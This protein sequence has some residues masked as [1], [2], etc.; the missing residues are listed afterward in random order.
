[1]SHH[2]LHG[3]HFPLEQH[4]NEDGW[5]HFCLLHKSKGRFPWQDY[6]LR[7]DSISLNTHGY[8][9]GLERDGFL[10]SAEWTLKE[11]SG[12][13]DPTWINDPQSQRCIAF[14]SMDCWVLR[15]GNLY[16]I[17][18]ITLY[19][20]I[21][22][23]RGA[24]V[25]PACPGSCSQ[26]SQSPGLSGWEGASLC[27]APAEQR[28][29]APPSP[30]PGTH[31]SSVSYAHNSPF[32]Q[33]SWETGRNHWI[34]S[35]KDWLRP[36]CCNMVPANSMKV[37]TLSFHIQRRISCH[38]NRQTMLFLNPSLATPY[39]F[40]FSHLTFCAWDSWR[41]FPSLP[42]HCV[43][44]HRKQVYLQ[45]T[46]PPPPRRPLS[47]YPALLICTIVPSHSAH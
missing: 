2:C 22:Y 36:G 19:Y 37:L 33:H 1:M 40:Y 16:C 13:R 5:A 7:K 24:E 12:E 41:T 26:R 9:W 3:L 6:W 20:I 35:A 38:G 32:A 8:L 18:I 21:L 17:I 31:D 14:N 28:V 10:N 25:N 39:I 29:W 11:C 23:P 43:C 30:S 15:D 42:L 27:N 45:G 34:Q 47:L 44:A 46:F 4:H